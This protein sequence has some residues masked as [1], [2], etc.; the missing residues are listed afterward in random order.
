MAIR[1]GF[2]GAALLG[3]VTTFGTA[4]WLTAVLVLLGLVGGVVAVE[5]IPSLR[6]DRG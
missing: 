5:A 4:L 3:V 1:A 2:A 6:R